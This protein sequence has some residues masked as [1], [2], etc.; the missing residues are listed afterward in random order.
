MCVFN[1]V[2]CVFNALLTGSIQDKVNS[3]KKRKRV[4]SS[5]NFNQIRYVFI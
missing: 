2:L 4:K 5:L 3:D 1:E